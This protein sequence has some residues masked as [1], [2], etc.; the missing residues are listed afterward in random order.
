MAD[1]VLTARMQEAAEVIADSAR[2]K[3]SWSERIPA[4]VHTLTAPGADTVLIVA[5]GAPA[6]H[7]I[8][9]EAPNAS[10]WKHPVFGRGPRETWHWVKQDPRRFLKP[11]AEEEA[12]HSVRVVAQAVNDWAKFLGYDET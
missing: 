3:S 9:F 11:A 12:G 7:A 1:P 4:S 8:T 10:Y 2:R 6:P 5:G